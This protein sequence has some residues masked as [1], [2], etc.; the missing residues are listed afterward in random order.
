[1]IMAKKAFRAMWGNKRAYVACVWLLSVGIMFYVAMNITSLDLAASRDS[2]YR[3]YRLADVFA[4]VNAAGASAAARLARIPGIA[5]AALRRVEDCRV[6]LPGSDKTITLRIISYDPGAASPINGAQLSGAFQADDDLFVAQSFLDAHGLAAGDSLDILV[7]GRQ[8]R[9]RIAGNA[10]TPEYAYTI[11]SA[12]EFMPDPGKFNFAFA[13]EKPFNDFLGTPN[14]YNS[15]GIELS[16]G[17]SFEDVEHAVRDELQK[18]GLLAL[19]KREDQPS[20]LYIDMEINAISAMSSVVPFVFCGIA[21]IILYLM[22]KRVIEQDR[23][24]IGTLKA[25]GFSSQRIVG[26]YMFYGLSTGCLGALLGAGSGYLVNGVLSGVMRMFFNLPEAR[27]AAGTLSIIATGMFAGLASGGLGAFMGASRVMRLQP[28]EAM[29]PEAPRAMKHDPLR[30]VPGAERLLTS[31]GSM[32]VRNIARA[33]F[34]SLFIAASIS[35]SFG[36]LVFFGSYPTMIDSMMFAQYTKSEVYDVKVAYRSPRG[37]KAAV[38]ELM[39]FDGVH[40]AEALLEMPVELSKNSRVAGVSL[41]GIPSGSQLYRIYD[42]KTHKTHPPPTE[43]LLLSE[44]LAEKLGA[45]VG[46]KLVARS[47]Y[48]DE[49]I[50]LIVAGLVTR[51]LGGAYIERDALADAFHMQ[52]M[53]TSAVLKADDIP[54]VKEGLK[55]AKNVASVVDASEAVAGF[56]IYMSMVDSMLVVYFLYGVAIAF[57]IIY[58]TSTISF[59]ERR[60]EFATLRVLGMTVPEISSIQ[61]FEYWMLAVFGVLLGLPYSSLIKRGLNAMIDLEAFAI[62]TYTQARE[63]LIGLLG[64]LV[65]VAISNRVS[66]RRIAKLD[67]VE[68]LKDIE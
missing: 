35:A 57:A 67:M 18:Y 41:V 49:D 68:S 56:E 55:E 23:S 19:Y 31:M 27:S 9:F 17:Y 62:P 66:R 37:A 30:F 60:R 25:F 33:K 13:A 11:P 7:G 52:G 53:S 26:H 5:D 46:D 1:M 45:A 50:K 36:I 29:K 58:N 22:L 3:E 28:A 20:V 48:L 54:Y 2:Y 4:D 15:I 24:Q 47:P 14:T 38:E 59:S 63:Y 43:G 21:V 61:S 65:A 40:S 32:A 8:A 64:V 44:S 10:S 39:R 16:L 6:L 42:E 12:S 34:R 51:S